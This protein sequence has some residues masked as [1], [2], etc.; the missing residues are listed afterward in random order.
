MI[1]GFLA[2]AAMVQTATAEPATTA[3][4]FTAQPDECSEFYPIRKGQP[5]PPAII[6]DNG[7]ARCSGVVSPLSEFARFQAI[8]SD[9]AAADRLSAMDVAILEAERDWYRTELERARD[10]KW[11]QRPAAHRW[12]GRLDVV[13]VAVA[14]TGTVTAVYN[15]GK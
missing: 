13:I 15:S 8:E 11:Y 2:V 5:I 10:V 9:A 12:A 3:A 14:L 1:G 7:V 6:A 4:R